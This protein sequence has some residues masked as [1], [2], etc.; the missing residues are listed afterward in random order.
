MIKIDISHEISFVDAKRNLDKEK[1]SFVKIV[2]GK[3]GQK[4]RQYES[5]TIDVFI[6]SLATVRNVKV[7]KKT[8]K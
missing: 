6:A 8:V 3:L 2:S 4:T 5:I 7:Y 1:R